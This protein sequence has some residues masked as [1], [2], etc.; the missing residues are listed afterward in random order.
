MSPKPKYQK[1]VAADMGSLQ[2]VHGANCDSGHFAEDYCTSGSSAVSGCSNGVNP[3]SVLTCE[4][5]GSLAD[6]DCIN[7]GLNAGDAC[8]PGGT[9]AANCSPTGG[10]AS[11]ACVTGDDAVWFCNNGGGQP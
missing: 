7:N 5:T 1:P 4:S 11:Q 10:S 3:T 2:P 6:N 8:N 9:A